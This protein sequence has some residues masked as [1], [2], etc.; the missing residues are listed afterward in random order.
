MAFDDFMDG[1]ALRVRPSERSALRIDVLVRL[2]RAGS[3]PL[4]YAAVARKSLAAVDDSRIVQL[5][6]R[7]EAL[8]E[9]RRFV[10]RV[11]VRATDLDGNRE[12]ATRL[13]RVGG[14]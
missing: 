8:H 12:M 6:P 4:R 9:R 10:A 11:R 5:K 14:G 1:F 13:L 7:R 2:R 3:R